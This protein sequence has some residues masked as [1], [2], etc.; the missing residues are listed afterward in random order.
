MLDQFKKIIQTFY[1][2]NNNELPDYYIFIANG[3]IRRFKKLNSESTDLTKETIKDINKSIE[4]LKKESLIE[5][6]KLDNIKIIWIFVNY[7]K[8]FEENFL[9]QIVYFKIK[10]QLLK[11]FL[12][13]KLI[14]S[15]KINELLFKE[16][17][18][19]VLYVKERE[20]YVKE[21]N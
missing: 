11:Y 14:F 15:V 16:W 13:K 7:K 18:L 2:I 5:N 19:N 12:D 4:N 10:D 1:N 3:D 21:G 8:L 9:R 6:D 20:I 17:E